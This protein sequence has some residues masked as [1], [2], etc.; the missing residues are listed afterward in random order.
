VVEQKTATKCHYNWF[1]GLNVGAFSTTLRAGPVW[2][3]PGAK[4]GRKAT[5]NRPKLE[6]RFEF[7]SKTASKSTQYTGIG[8]ETIAT[9][10]RSEAARGIRGP[11]PPA[12]SKPIKKG[13]GARCLPY[14]RLDRFLV[15]FIKNIIVICTGKV[16]TLPS[17]RMRT[18]ISTNEKPSNR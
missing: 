15:L 3:G 7:P 11:I 8:S 12:R 13:P 4:F 9:E 6:S 17:F 2:R 16:L 5:E 18:V 14:P 10:A 1:P